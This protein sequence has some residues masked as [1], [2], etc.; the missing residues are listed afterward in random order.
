M[1]VIFLGAGASAP[2]GYPTMDG[3]QSQLMNRV[4]D[5]ERDL[6]V[7]LPS[8]GGNKDVEVVL[9]HLTTI[10][11]LTERG[12]EKIF[13][14]S[15]VEFFGVGRTQAMSFHKFIELCSSL[16]EIIQDTIFD[17]YQFRPESTKDINFVEPSPSLRRIDIIEL[18][19]RISSLSVKEAR[20]PGLG[21]STVHYLRLNAMSSRSLQVYG[22]TRGK[23]E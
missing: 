18:R 15:W 6:L 5:T 1:V 7:G 22:K 21:K 16:R 12:L 8:L 4:E 11:G 13:E 10:E 3:L 14:K 23:L 2:F 20:R 17:V 19:K 9:Q